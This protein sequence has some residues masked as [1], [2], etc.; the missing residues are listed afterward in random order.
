MARFLNTVSQR[1]EAEDL[2]QEYFFQLS[3]LCL[4]ALSGTSCMVRK[5]ILKAVKLDDT[6]LFLTKYGTQLI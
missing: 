1:G 2:D 4:L 6:S 3:L 5:V